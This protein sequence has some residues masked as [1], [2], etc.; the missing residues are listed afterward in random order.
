VT[1]A[2]GSALPG[3]SR[4]FE[5]AIPDIDGEPAIA[6]TLYAATEEL[7]QAAPELR[8][9]AD[10]IADVIGPLVHITDPATLLIDDPDPAALL[11]DDQAD[12]LAALLTDAAAQA[13]TLAAILTD[14]AEQAD[15]LAA[16]LTDDHPTSG[17]EA[18]PGVRG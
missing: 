17:E 13:N 16:T 11:P 8:A 12:H 2:D 7:E 10:S 3:Q 15:G 14:A 6:D 9:T 5:R 1:R 18:P 4:D